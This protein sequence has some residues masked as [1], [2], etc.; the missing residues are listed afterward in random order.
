MEKIKKVKLLGGKCYNTYCGSKSTC[1]IYSEGATSDLA[2]YMG[3]EYVIDYCDLYT[4]KELIL[5]EDIP[6]TGVQHDS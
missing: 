3:M 5:G 4:P 6:H 1:K 2:I